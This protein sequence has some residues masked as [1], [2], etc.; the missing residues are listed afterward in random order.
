[1]MYR[2]GYSYKDA[3]QERVL[4]IRMKH[5]HF[6]ELLAM[7]VV[8]HGQVL[9]VGCNFFSM[10]LCALCALCALFALFRGGLV[11][12]G[13]SSFFFF[14]FFFLVPL[15]IFLLTLG[16]S[17][18]RC[19]DDEIG[20]ADERAKG[21]R[22]QWDPERSPKLEV[23]PWRSIQIG[24]S[25]GVGKIWAEE[26]IVGIEDVTERAMTLKEVVENEKGVALEELVKRGL[27]PEERV[28]ELPEELRKVLQMDE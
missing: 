4:A 9:T 23:L 11:G 18:E 2:C 13:W 25:G 1:M 14:S 5:E 24:I 3:G 10:I 12:G 7:G 22:V 6:R 21:V 15:E 17:W 26:W 16:L 27:V 8:C 20:Q 19:A 28:Y